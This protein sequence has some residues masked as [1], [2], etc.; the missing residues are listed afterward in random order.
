MQWTDTE[1]GLPCLIRR[2]P[3]GGLCGYVGVS[4]G[5]PFFE[6]HYNDC[7]SVDVHGGLTF[8]EHCDGDEHGICHIVEPGE[9]D[10]VWWLGFDCVHWGDVAPKMNSFESLTGIDYISDRHYWTLQEVQTETAS[11]ARQLAALA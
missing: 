11:L 7:Q 4:T 3:M 8:S 6:K 1:T 2:G 5:H 9:N 10:N